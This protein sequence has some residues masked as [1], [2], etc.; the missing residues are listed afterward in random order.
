M[1]MGKIGHGRKWLFAEM[2]HNLEMLVLV[3]YF[4]MAI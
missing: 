3:P 2:T 1:V 4:I